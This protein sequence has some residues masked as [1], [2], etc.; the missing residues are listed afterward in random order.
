MH[1]FTKP[2]S[3]LI[4][5]GEG[6]VRCIIKWFYSFFLFVHTG[7][8]SF[9]LRWAYLVSYLGV[10]I[11]TPNMSFKLSSDLYYYNNILAYIVKIQSTVIIVLNTK[12]LHLL[13]WSI[14]FLL[15][16]LMCTYVYYLIHNSMVIFVYILMNWDK[17]CVLWSMVENAHNYS[18]NYRCNTNQQYP[19]WQHRNTGLPYTN[20]E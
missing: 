17:I 19:W 20:S 18:T 16:L 1:F 8:Y 6:D 4:D 12:I 15:I 2:M 14:I 13:I 7:M 9:Y 11:F 5:F 3:V 10:R